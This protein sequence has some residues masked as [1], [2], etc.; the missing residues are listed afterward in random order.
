MKRTL[1]LLVSSLAILAGAVGTLTAVAGA[2][3][4]SGEVVTVT[5]RTVGTVAAPAPQVVV[6]GATL[7]AP[8]RSPHRSLGRPSSGPE[9]TASGGSCSAGRVALT[10][11][12]GPSA[13]VS[14]PLT[15][16]LRRLDVPATF[17]MVGSRVD[18]APEVARLV[19]RRGFTIGDHTYAHTDLTTL[20]DHGIRAGLTAMR[21][22]LQRA[23]VPHLSTFVRPPYGATDPRV[24]RVIRGMGLTSVLWNVDSEDWTGIATPRIVHDVVSQ[25]VAHGRAGSVVLQH[26][27]VT[28]SPATLAA[29]PRE[30]R[31]LR[32]RGFCFVALDED[33]RPAR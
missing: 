7:R 2:A 29:V 23:G 19:A 15:R 30:V 28:N 24:E 25:V 3:G 13:T 1:L 11:D 27:G 33:G 22:A 18:A 14:A 5:A 31:V 6:P 4:S 32:H 26:D 21:R 12:D 10:F 20:D 9:R 16:L 17:F 8:H